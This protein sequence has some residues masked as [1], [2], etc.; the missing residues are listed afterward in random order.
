VKLS[1]IPPAPDGS[2]ANTQF[3]RELCDG[4]IFDRLAAGLRFGMHVK[5]PFL[6]NEAF[7]EFVTPKK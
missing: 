4:E 3:L 6:L 7:T 5:A 1:S 2:C